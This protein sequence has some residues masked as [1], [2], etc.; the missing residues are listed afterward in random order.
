MPLYLLILAFG[1]IALCAMTKGGLGLI[2][3]VWLFP[4]GLIQSV[5]IQTALHS[6]LLLGYAVYFTLAILLSFARTIAR[7]QA[8]L[9]VHLII[10]IATSVGATRPS[11]T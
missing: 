11:G 6:A 1:L 3:A 4:A 8:I 7:A 5:S 10:V 2:T 9:I